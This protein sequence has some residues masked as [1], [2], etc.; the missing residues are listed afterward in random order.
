MKPM[1][2][3]SGGLQRVHTRGF[4]TNV[5]SKTDD[6]EALSLVAPADDPEPLSLAPPVDDPEAGTEAR[7]C[8]TRRKVYCRARTCRFAVLKHMCFLNT[9][10]TPGTPKLGLKRGPKAPQ[11]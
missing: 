9:A 11:I 6:P 3:F 2:Y 5:S 10:R 7:S 8:T 4:V 1:M